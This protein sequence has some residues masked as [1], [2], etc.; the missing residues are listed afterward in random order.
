MQIESNFNL[1]KLN[2]FGIAAKA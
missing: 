1:S 2:T